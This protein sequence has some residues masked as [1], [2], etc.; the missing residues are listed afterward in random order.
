MRMSPTLGRTR[1]MSGGLKPLGG[2]GK[3]VTVAGE[4]TKTIDALL[5]GS[6]PRKLVV[7]VGR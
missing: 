4:R 3:E 7:Y 2:T 5:E 6:F 1:L